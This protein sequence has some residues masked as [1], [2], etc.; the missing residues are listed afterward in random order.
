MRKFSICAIFVLLYFP[1]LTEAKT[2]ITFQNGK[3]LEIDEPISSIVFQETNTKSSQLDK[4]PEGAIKLLFKKVQ[5]GEMSTIK[6][7][8]MAGKYL[9]PGDQ[10]KLR[11]LFSSENVVD[12]ETKVI[13]EKNQQA[14]VLVTLVTKNGKKQGKSPIQLV[15]QDGGWKINYSGMAWPSFLDMSNY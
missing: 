13:K 7:T 11:A 6:N 5:E 14:E 4:T 3:I 2:V 9:D 1:I 12:V 8:L 15:F 10:G